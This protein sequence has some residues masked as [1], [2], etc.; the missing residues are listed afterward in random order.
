MI[1]WKKIL[2]FQDKFYPNWRTKKPRLL[3]STALAG[4]VGEVCGTITHLDGGGTNNRKYN[5]TQ[6]LHQA[7]DTYIQLVLLV[8]RSG[9]TE[10]EFES[11]FN[12]VMNKELPERLKAKEN[13]LETAK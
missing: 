12:R 4:E 1:G 6:V 13:P 3:F 7:V 8:A 2:A 9:F 11:E 10:N 5:E